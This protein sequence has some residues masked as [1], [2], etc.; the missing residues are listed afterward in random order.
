MKLDFR[1]L[2]FLFLLY[3]A[4]R[5]WFSVNQTKIKISVFLFEMVA[6]PLPFNGH[7]LCCVNELLLIWYKLGLLTFQ[8]MIFC[9]NNSNDEI[10]NQK[11]KRKVFSPSKKWT[12]VPWNYKP[13]CNQW[14]MLSPMFSC[15]CFLNK[16]SK[17]KIFT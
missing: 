13:V 1:F 17:G 9:L 7:L 2:F 4:L 3:L 5:W 15:R 8:A 16:F 11:Q 10:V 6:M 12:E 14:A